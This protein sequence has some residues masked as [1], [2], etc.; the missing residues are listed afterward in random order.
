MFYIGGIFHQNLTNKRN[1]EE[2]MS[3]YQIPVTE[4][5]TAIKRKLR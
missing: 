2:R 5:I 4:R 1:T 3:Q